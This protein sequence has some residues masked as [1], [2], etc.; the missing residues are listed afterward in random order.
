MTQVATITELVEEAESTYEVEIEITGGGRGWTATAGE[1]TAK[2][3]SKAGALEALVV[4]LDAA[5]A[6]AEPGEEIEGCS[7]ECQ[8]SQ[9]NICQCACGG[10]NHGIGVT[11]KDRKPTVVV[12]EKPCRCGCGQTT[13]RTFVPGH[14]ARF[15]ALMALKEW[16]DQ[17]DHDGPFDEAKASKEKKA[18]VRKIARERRATKRAADKAVQEEAAAKMIASIK[19]PARKSKAQAKANTKVQAETAEALGDLPF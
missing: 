8:S 13:K 10:E 2:A 15:H 17:S 1:V 5:E 3:T 14:D 12:G 11:V 6:E 9:S 16:W 18:A 4:A 7:D 19:A